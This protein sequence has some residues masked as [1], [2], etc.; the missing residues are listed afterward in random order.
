M[1]KQ[2]FKHGIFKK[3]LKNRFLCLVEIDGEDT[4][5]YIPSSCRLSNF[6]DLTGKE[7]LRGIFQRVMRPKRF[8]INLSR[9][10]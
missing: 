5:C 2:S 3:E 7:V 4:L 1:L 9:M 8:T 6:I 10:K